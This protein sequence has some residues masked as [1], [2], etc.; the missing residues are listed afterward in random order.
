MLNLPQDTTVRGCSCLM[1][2]LY[3]RIQAYDATSLVYYPNFVPMK[4]GP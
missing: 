3:P 1:M 2:N 4:K